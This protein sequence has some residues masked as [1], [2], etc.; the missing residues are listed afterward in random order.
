MIAI[1]IENTITILILGMIA[2]TIWHYV[3]PM[4]GIKP[5]I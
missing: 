3:A 4:I 1:N 2:F 5:A